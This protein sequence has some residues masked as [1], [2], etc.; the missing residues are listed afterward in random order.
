MILR[1]V[2]TNG[3][4]D[5]ELAVAKSKIA[6]RL[7]RRS[8]RPMGRMGAI[9]SAWINNREFD[10][11]DAELARYEAVTPGTI[12]ELLA[13]FPVNDPTVVAYGPLASIG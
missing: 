7:V 6:S 5:E 3:V 8:E 13:R 1:D 2:Q 10:D 4:T 11:I 12:R 9:A